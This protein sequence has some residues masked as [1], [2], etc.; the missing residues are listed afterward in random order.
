MSSVPDGGDLI[1]ASGG[2]REGDHLGDR[3]FAELGS[4]DLELGG[5][6]PHV[7]VAYETWG[8]LN[9]DA[10]N[11]VLVLHA[12][13][14]DSHVVGPA[15]PGHLTAG[16]WDGLI[17]PDAPID[18]RKWFVVAPNVL[19]GCQGSTG[20]SSL[21][22]G[23]R[24][25]SL[26]DGPR[27]SSLR[28]DG[29]R[30]LSLRDASQWG[31]AFP[32]I[33][34]RDQVAVEA[35]LADHLGISTWASLVGG[36]MGAMRVLEWLVGYPSRT[37]SALVL[38]VGAT[39]TGDQIGTQSAQLRAITSDPHWRAGDYYDAADGEGP[40]EGMGLAR[41]IAHL[42]YRSADELQVRFG[43][44]P[45]DGEDPLRDGRFA[46]QSYLDH[47]ATKLA[48]R[49]DAGT[50]VALTDAMNTHDVGRGRGGVA[51]ALACIIAPVIIAGV[52]S[53]RLYPI[54]LQRELAD[55]IPTTIGGLRVV[56]SEFGHD[57]FLIER[58]A[59]GALVRETLAVADRVMAC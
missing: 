34:V 52:D 24:E 13:T 50:Y 18:S 9:A 25:S 57:G 58:D 49:F 15:G 46:V 37:S 35:A 3:R 21:R 11:A 4:F 56:H 48:R 54:A 29:Q 1:P 27:E 55:Q 51:A 30:H 59:V 10:S 38:A 16:W 26:R 31:S 17:G 19:G 39:A 23:P 2:W 6:L 47:Q 44:E 42:T 14:G 28:A 12:L 53:D 33:T 41:R 8:E 32:R 40:H 20:P 5:Q 43:N 7:R 45:Q 36:S 22:D